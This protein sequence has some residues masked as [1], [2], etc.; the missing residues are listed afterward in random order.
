MRAVRNFH[1]VPPLVCLYCF[2][3]SIG[4]HSITLLTVSQAPSTF[5]PELFYELMYIA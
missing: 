4:T 2:L 5:N 3:P 1:P